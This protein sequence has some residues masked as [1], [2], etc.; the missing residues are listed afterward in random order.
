VLYFARILRA[1]IT[2]VE[3]SRVKA[4]IALFLGAVVFWGIYDQ[5]GSTLSVFT[6]T[7]TDRDIFGYEVPTAWFQ[8]INPIFIIAFA[9]VF[10]WMW[11]KLADRA[12]SLPLKFAIAMVGIGLSFVIMIPPAVMAS[13]GQQ[14]SAA[15]IVTVYLI[16]TWA[17]LLL[18]PTGLSATTV[19]APAGYGSQMLALWFLAVAVGDSLAGQILRAMDNAA[20]QTVFA[21]FAA[22]ALAFSLVMFALVRPIKRLMAGVD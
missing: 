16:Q 3:K 11:T 1:P 4:F 19:L 18:S 12:P 22:A 17:E 2:P 9:P 5:A 20:P 10:A 8:S 14:S 15:W 6:E 21:V 13:N 7:W